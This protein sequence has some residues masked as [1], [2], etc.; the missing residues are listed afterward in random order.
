[1]SANVD[2]QEVRDTTKLFMKHRLM[3]GL[4]ARADESDL[5]ALL[6]VD[7][8]ISTVDAYLAH[9]RVLV[10][11][12]RRVEFSEL[13][14]AALESFNGLKVADW[15]VDK[16]RA[17]TY[18]PGQ[19]QPLEST[20]AEDE[21]SRGN[22]QHACDWALKRLSAN[23]T[24]ICSLVLAAQCYAIIGAKPQPEGLSPVQT[25]LLLS[26]SVLASRSGSVDKAANE[27]G[28]LAQNHRDL[29]AMRAT[30]GFRADLWADLPQIGPSECVGNCRIVPSHERRTLAV[31][32]PSG[33]EVSARF[34]PGKAAQ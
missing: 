21:F 29:P 5:C 1:M 27:I 23:P 10:R 19:T 33:C 12:A 7:A 13:L 30:A 14:P 4:D 34:L 9:L 32:L 11:F 28:K 6:S 15:R 3:G 22:Y 8:S 31:R 26:F 24:D 25:D 18:G 17:L 2:V 20:E 16:L